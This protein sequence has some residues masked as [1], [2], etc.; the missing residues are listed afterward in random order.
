MI[1]G[2]YTAR[3]GLLAHQEKMNVISNNMANVNTTGFKGQRVSFTDL[4]YQNINRPTAENPAMIG[5]GIKI[6]KSALIVTQ[7][8]LQ[9]TNRF[10]DFALTEPGQ[11]FAVQSPTG[12]IV[13]TR[14]GGFILSRDEDGSFFLSVPNGD[15]VLDSE[16]EPIEI[17]FED[18]NG[19]PIIDINAIGIF[20]FDNPYGLY[21]LGANYYTPSENSGEAVAIEGNVR[22][23]RVGFL[24]GSNVEMATEMVRVIEASRAFSFSSRMVQVADEVEHTVNTL[25]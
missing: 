17:E 11:F 23:I 14:A 3:S 1:R 13:Y 16:F 6:K 8:P 2:F 18:E 15:R 19:A 9:A 25:R 24:E 20:R 5:H 10:L 22:G 12:E 21:L 4:M 7:G